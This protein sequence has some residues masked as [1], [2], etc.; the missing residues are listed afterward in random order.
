ML[1]R[2]RPEGRQLTAR[3]GH[4]ARRIN[5]MRLAP[6]ALIYAVGTAHSQTLPPGM[7]MHRLQAGVPDESGWVL[8]KSTQGAFS[9][10]M[11][12][13]FNDFNLD[14]LTGQENVSRSYVVGC[15]RPDGEKYSV[16]RIEYRG[17]AEMARR[18]FEKNKRAS[19]FPGAKK[20]ALTVK[21]SPALDITISEPKRCG[22][23]RFLL[24]GPTTILMAAEAPVAQCR[25]LNS[26]VPS[27]MESLAIDEPRRAQQGTPAKQPR[28]KDSPGE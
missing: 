10:R 4:R 26:Q 15:K 28:A 24:V 6:I 23:L 17:G 19:A 7:T 18:F 5:G 14:D 3:F 1:R 20:N 9:V 16:T 27:F 13:T 11:P 22:T 8:A 21:D 12:C 25:H 2:L